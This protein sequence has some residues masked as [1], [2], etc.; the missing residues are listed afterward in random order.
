MQTDLIADEIV[1][2]IIN[3]DTEHRIVHVVFSP[4]TVPLQAIKRPLREAVKTACPVSFKAS[5]LREVEAS[6]IASLRQYG[7]RVSK[8]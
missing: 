2:R 4:V 3:S 8:R 6:V 5:M 1:K 7:I